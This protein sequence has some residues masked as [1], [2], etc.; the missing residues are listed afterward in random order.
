MK[1]KLNI[2]YIVL[3]LFLGGMMVYGGLGK[4][5]K[6]NPT[7]V[8][9]VEKAEKFT[10]PEKENTL[11]KVLYINGA[12]QTGYFWELLGICELVFGLLLIIQGTS[13]IGAVLLLPITLHIFLFH[14][15]LELDEIGELIMT[16]GLLLSNLVL[17]FKEYSN[18]K[19]LIWIKVF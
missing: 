9:V 11:Q 19:H 12:K 17:V 5:E 7:P 6:T 16:G 13:F 14:A 4:F 3:R 15:F 8:E 2:I 1:N 18:W 10:S